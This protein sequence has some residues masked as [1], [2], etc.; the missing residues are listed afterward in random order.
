MCCPSLDNTPPCTQPSSRC[1]AAAAD[2]VPFTQE[3]TSDCSFQISLM[4]SQNKNF[5]LEASPQPE[6][7][8]PQNSF[9]PVMERCALCYKLLQEKGVDY[10]A[11]SLSLQLCIYQ[12]KK[13]S[14]EQGQN[15]HKNKNEFCNHMRNPCNMQY[16]S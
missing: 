12:L 13:C 6:Q 8:F 1:C 4:P 14:H 11:I 3:F 2:S 7:A 9:S 10:R 15:M 16:P 5:A